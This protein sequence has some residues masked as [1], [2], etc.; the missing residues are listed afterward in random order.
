MRELSNKE[1]HV[2]A[3]GETYAEVYSLA[4]ELA[5]QD[6]NKLVDTTYLPQTAITLIYGINFGIYLALLTPIFGVYAAGSLVIDGYEAV[7]SALLVRT[8]IIGNAFILFPSPLHDLAEA[9]R[10]NLG[11]G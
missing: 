8:E 1:Q 3:G 9:F 11:E 5:T 4:Q 6:Y 2:V 10:A 7:A